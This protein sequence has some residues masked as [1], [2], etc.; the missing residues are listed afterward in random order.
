MDINDH[1]VRLTERISRASLV[2][3]I[4]WTA[5]WTY[6]ANVL[7]ICDTWICGFTE[8]HLSNILVAQGKIGKAKPKEPYVV[9]RGSLPSYLHPSTGASTFSVNRYQGCPQDPKQTSSYDF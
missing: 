3:G 2:N 8:E 7:T 4:N 1:Y 9:H 5:N 6:D